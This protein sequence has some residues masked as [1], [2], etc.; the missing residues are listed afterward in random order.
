M[1]YGREFPHFP[2]VAEIAPHNFAGR[3][4]NNELPERADTA[5]QLIKTLPSR[6]ALAPR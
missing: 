1:H 5:R 4:V 3:A 6:L 2:A